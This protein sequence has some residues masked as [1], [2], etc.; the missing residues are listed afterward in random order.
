MDSMGLPL[1]P[2]PSTSDVLEPITLTNLA[3]E[4]LLAI[5]DCVHAF[6]NETK[7]TTE[8]R[9]IAPQ[10]LLYLALI[11]R[12]FHSII[13]PILYTHFETSDGTRAKEKLAKFMV[14]IL[15]RPDLAQQIRILHT[16]WYCDSRENFNYEP[17]DWTRVEAATRE[18]LP[19]REN[20]PKHYPVYQGFG[21]FVEEWAEDIASGYWDAII[22]LLVSRLP[23]LEVLNFEGWF[24]EIDGHPP[25]INFPIIMGAIERAIDL[26]KRSE[27]SSPLAMSNLQHITT[28]HSKPKREGIQ[29]YW[30]FPF[31]NIPSVRSFEG[32][33]T[34]NDKRH[35]FPPELDTT[36]DRGSYVFNTK[37]LVLDRSMLDRRT[38]E[39]FLSL[40]PHLECLYYSHLIW[41]SSGSEV[42]FVLQYFFKPIQLLKPYLK[43]L[44]LLRLGSVGCLNAPNWE[45]VSLTDFYQLKTIG[46]DVTLMFEGEASDDSACLAKL[47]PPQLESLTLRGA[48]ARYVPNILKLIAQRDTFVPALKRLDLRWKGIRGQGRAAL[49]ESSLRY[50]FSKEEADASFNG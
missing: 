2:A 45:I 16:W 13:K 37:K 42:P 14:T 4:I 48:L 1:D 40:F 19:S 47:L 10:C 36:W 39:K 18:V 15:A 34:E 46:M 25:T 29:V 28:K 33:G 6:P 20:Q 35:D 5:V 11:C 43:H 30:L 8:H 24:N 38:L 31:L 7:V 3:P 22:T 27:L 21:D 12:Q 17:E 32:S 44:T 41:G 23:N 9:V 49:G 50:G 26:Q